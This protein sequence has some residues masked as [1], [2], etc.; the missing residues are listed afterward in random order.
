MFCPKCGTNQP[1]DLKFCKTCGANLQ[2]VRV[3]VEAR[4]AG[5]KFDWSKTWVAEMF[6]SEGERKRREEE[7]ERLR[8]ITPDVKRYNEIKGGVITACVGLALMI[9][10]A[11]FMEGIIRGG[12]VPHDA[13]EILSRLWVVGVIPLFV[14]LGL[15]INGI[16]VSKKQAEAAAR[17][18]ELRARTQQP[19]PDALPKGAQPRPLRPADT[20]EFITPGFSVTEGTT[21]HLGT[22]APKPQDP[23]NT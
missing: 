8:G 20:S 14:G 10:L 17:A 5:E 9:F 16:F 13:V 6:L 11:I 18:S 19:A 2:A 21:Q 15:M 4:D 12:N 7:L 1:D 23:Y 22:P 3:A